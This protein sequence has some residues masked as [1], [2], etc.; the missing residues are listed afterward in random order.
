MVVMLAMTAH[1]QRCASCRH[2]TPLDELT[3]IGD[4]PS[5]PFVVC[6]ECAKADAEEQRRE[7]A[8]DVE[9]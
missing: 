3:D 7:H 4:G 6:D 5:K 9:F 8:P 1:C 2:W